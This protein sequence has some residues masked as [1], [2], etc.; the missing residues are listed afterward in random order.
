MG[1]LMIEEFEFRVDAELAGRLFAD[2]E[3]EKRSAVRKVRLDGT[4]PRI[5]RIAELQR[6]FREREGRPF[7]FG[8]DIRR[9]Y[10]EKEIASASLFQLE[11][12]NRF[13]PAGEECGTT[14]DDGSACPICLSGAR[15]VGPLILETRR[16]P[17]RHE[18]SAT[19]AEEVV[20]SH[21][22]VSLLRREK[23]S[24]IDFAPVVSRSGSS[25]GSREW[26]QPL[27]PY[28]NSQLCSPTRVGDEPFDETA[29]PVACPRG[30]L[31]GLNQLSEVFIE[32]DSR[33]SHDVVSTRQFVGVRRGVLRPRRLILVSPKVREILVAARLT[34]CRFDVAH[35][36]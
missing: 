15:Q 2:A 23:I 9:R 19:I 24:G 31:A 25:A 34:G 7:Y 11:I 14:Y 1:T 26:Y 30:D 4:D 35:L 12:T 29:G 8:W 10:S 22:V 32:K 27:I 33:G 5:A 3:G 21:C 28:T 36:V 18:I 17:K 6:E 13:E 20:F 16:V